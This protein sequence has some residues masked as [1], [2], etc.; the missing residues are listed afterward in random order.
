MYYCCQLLRILFGGL[1]WKCAKVKSSRWGHWQTLDDLLELHLDS[2]KSL[3]SKKKKNYQLQA[4]QC[5]ISTDGKKEQ[6]YVGT[7]QF[8]FSRC[9]R[10]DHWWCCRQIL[11]QRTQNQ[12]NETAY[13]SLIL[14]FLTSSEWADWICSQDQSWDIHCLPQNYFQLSQLLSREGIVFTYDHQ[15][16]DMFLPAATTVM[17]HTPR[18]IYVCALWAARSL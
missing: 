9:I 6:M 11:L 16:W 12:F 3:S 1:E 17:K 15:H 7:T 10:M 2:G 5:S 18:S 8:V 4:R 14:I 13:Q